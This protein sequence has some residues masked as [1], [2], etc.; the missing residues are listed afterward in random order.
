MGYK[1]IYN[2][3]IYIYIY[4]YITV[5]YVVPILVFSMKRLSGTITELILFKIKTTHLFPKEY[6]ILLIHLKYVS[7]HQFMII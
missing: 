7:P 6:T 2:M 1:Q 4:I 3:Y 5:T